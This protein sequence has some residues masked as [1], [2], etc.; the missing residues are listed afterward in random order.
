M[1]N[2]FTFFSW[3]ESKSSERSLHLP[4]AEKHKRIYYFKKWKDRC[5]TLFREFYSRQQLVLGLCRKNDDSIP[6]G[7]CTTGRIYQYQQSQ[8][9]IFRDRLDLAPSRKRKSY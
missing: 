8:F 4:S 7:H 6:G 1:A 5:R 9:T 2:N 3:V